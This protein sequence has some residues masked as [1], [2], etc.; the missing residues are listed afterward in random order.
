M[1]YR[2]TQRTAGPIEGAVQGAVVYLGLSLGIVLTIALS[3]FL[4]DD[5]LVVSS[6]DNVLFFAVRFGFDQLPIVAPLLAFGLAVFYVASDRGD[7]ASVTAAA[8]AA[9]GT[10][11][12]GLLLLVL[13]LVLAPS[14]IDVS[15]GDEFLVLLSSA[16]GSVVTAG[17]TGIGFDLV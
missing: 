13:V 11:V 5:S 12:S 15:I 16:I 9:A 8:G 1:S 4:V 10:I 14:G 17:I 3:L 6:S 7:P 2:R